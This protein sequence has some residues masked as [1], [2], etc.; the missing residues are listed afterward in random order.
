MGG[1]VR[2]FGQDFRFG[3]R[4][5]ERKNE[6]LSKFK[7]E[8]RRADGSGR[9]SKDR[10]A[11]EGKSASSGKLV[12]TLTPSSLF[13]SLSLG[14]SQIKERGKAKKVEKEEDIG[15][16]TGWDGTWEWD[17]TPPPLEYP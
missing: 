16:W 5:G 13:P 8:Q 7:G 10:R 15:Y 1:L 11:R 3:G 14:G 17:A 9:G 4:V 12:V 2:A 6:M